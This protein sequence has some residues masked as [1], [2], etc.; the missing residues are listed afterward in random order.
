MFNKT[1]MML[2]QNIIIVKTMFTHHIKKG[3][4]FET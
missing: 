3:H 1:E 2:I 4:I